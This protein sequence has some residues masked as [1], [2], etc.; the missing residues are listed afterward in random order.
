MDYIITAKCSSSELYH[1][2]IK[3]QKW[4]IRRYQNFDGSYTKA[5]LKRYQ[6][7]LDMYNEIDEMHKTA[8]TLAKSKGVRDKDGNTHYFSKEEKDQL[9]AHAKEVKDTRAVAKAK[10]NKDYKHLRQDKLGDQGKKLYEKGY[11]INGKRRVTS[12]MQ[13][14]G[15]L[16]LSSPKLINNPLVRQYAPAAVQSFVRTYGKQLMVAGG[17][18]V[19]TSAAVDVA[20]AGID[21]KLRAYYSHTSNY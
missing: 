17:T 18:L 1:H 4:G 7:S 12:A 14:V 13:T 5:G 19:A 8:K 20:T 3:G 21:N 16:A 9:K 6:H 2:G 15:I 11:R 10:L